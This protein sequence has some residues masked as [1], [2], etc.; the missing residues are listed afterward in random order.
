VTY[1]VAL[2]R[3][4]LATL[5]GA[6]LGIE[7][8]WRAKNAGIKTNSLVALGA[9]G[10]ALMSDTFGPDNHNPAQLAAAVVGGIGFIGAGVI[11]HRGATVQ[12]L[13]TAATMWSNASMG[14]AAGLG[15]IGVAAVIAGGILV[16]Q[17]IGREIERH[18]RRIKK[19]GAPA[20]FEL[21]VDGDRESFQQVRHIL[22]DEK[23]TI[24]RR[25]LARH[26]GHLSLRMAF[27]TDTPSPDLTVMEE[28]LVELAGIRLVEV[29]QLGLEE[30]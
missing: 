20:R 3:L 23:L 14:V 17:F 11:L 4:A 1:D 10:F 24:T 6:L 22:A 2:V 21:R 12:G 16:V 27:R 15:H 28:K 19:R 9:A 8:E 30:D 29:R 13:T 26:D 5:F 7:R 18:V 25:S